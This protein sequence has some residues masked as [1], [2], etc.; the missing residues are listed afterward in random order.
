MAMNVIISR[1]SI[2]NLACKIERYAL[3]IIK[4]NFIEA[5]Q[6]WVKK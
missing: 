3:E 1:L 4:S 5:C 2:I 6:N